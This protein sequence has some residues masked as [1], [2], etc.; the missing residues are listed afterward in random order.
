MITVSVHI[1]PAPETLPA[2]EGLVQL[3]QFAVDSPVEALERAAA[4]LQLRT[5]AL[6][7]P[8]GHR[9]VLVVQSG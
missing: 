5:P 2:P 1:E 6:S 9:M 3:Q 8:D 7:I 4:Y